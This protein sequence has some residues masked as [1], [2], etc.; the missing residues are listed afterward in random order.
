MA[1]DAA[2]VDV[3]FTG[4]FYYAP[5]GATAPTDASSALPAAY[6]DVGLIS[7]DGVRDMPSSSAQQIEAWQGAQIVRTVLTQAF[8]EVA[9]TMIESN[10]NSLE[11][12]YAAAV[13]T[14]DGSVAIDPGKT[15]GIRAMVLDY[16]DGDKYVR[17]Y[18]PRGEVT[19]RDASEKTSGDAVGYPLTIT[20]Y[21]DNTL[22]FAGKR[23]FSALDV[24]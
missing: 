11:L 9:F 4:A 17:L 5:L 12:Y 23:F 15:G 2:N 6:R 3:A 21:K 20:A 10:P 18:L 8:I 19:A 22:G 16:V 13:N 1:L 7:S 24:T 14:S